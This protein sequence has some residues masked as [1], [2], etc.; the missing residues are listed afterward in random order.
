[1]RIL[2]LVSLAVTLLPALVYAAP[3]EKNCASDD[4]LVQWL[5]QGDFE[6]VDNKLSSAIADHD[7]GAISDMAV[8]DMLIEIDD[9]ER[10]C[11]ETAI[12]KWVSAKPKSYAAAVA[13]GAHLIRQA[14]KARGN[15]WA[16]KTSKAQFAAMKEWGHKAQLEL[17]RSLKLHPK[18]IFTY[19]RLIENAYVVG[20]EGEPERWLDLANK[21]APSNI[22]ARR[23]YI[24]FAT[25]RWD[26]SYEKM[27]NVVQEMRSSG[28]PQWNQDCVEAVFHR[29]WLYDDNRTDEETVD[30]LGPIVG[31]TCSKAKDHY[32]RASALWRLNRLKEAEQDFG[33]AYELETDT[34]NKG[35][36]VYW[37]GRARKELGDT[38][39]AISDYEVAESLGYPSGIIAVAWMYRFGNKQIPSDPKKALEL[40]EKALRT[41]KTGEALRCVASFYFDGL[42]VKEDKKRAMS[43]LIKSAN[44][45]DSLSM[46]SYADMLWDGYE[47][48]QDR[49]AAVQ[50]WCKSAR[51][52][53]EVGNERLMENLGFDSDGA[54]DWTC[55]EMA[56]F[57]ATPEVVKAIRY[58]RWYAQRTWDRVKGVFG[59]N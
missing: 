22:I 10:K 3:R 1:M 9:M 49:A 6:R 30:S 46:Q 17:E 28:A 51:A 59:K 13:N 12:T 36:Y 55:E 26:G 15:A 14:W 20:K 4:E 53:N 40:C 34:E 25:P 48:K 19:E 7:R 41:D 29:T 54:S 44:A 58:P 24:R 38:A 45:G 32:T 27:W 18:P 57:F 21:V 39:A 2:P 52:G 16:S 31:G 5:V 8:L 37:R 11:V 23:I 33:R 43:M 35:Y 50:W 56:G 42:I 47:I